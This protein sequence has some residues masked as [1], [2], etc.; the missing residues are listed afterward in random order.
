MIQLKFPS[1][2]HDLFHRHLIITFGCMT[3]CIYFGKW[4]IP[5]KNRKDCTII[6]KN[7]HLASK[8][9]TYI[10]PKDGSY[11]RFISNSWYE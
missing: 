9:G 6:D 11:V 4:I 3:D 1:H 5:F 10:L 8:N 7:V 2:G